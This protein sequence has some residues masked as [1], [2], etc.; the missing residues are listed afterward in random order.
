MKKQVIIRTTDKVGKMAAMFLMM[1]SVSLNTQGQQQSDFTPIMAET[2]EDTAQSI[3][4]VPPDGATPVESTLKGK[5][6]VISAEQNGQDVLAEME[7]FAQSMETSLAEF[8]NIEFFGNGKFIVTMMG[9]EFEDSY[10]TVDNVT[11]AMETRVRSELWMKDNNVMILG[12]DGSAIVF[13]STIS[14]KEE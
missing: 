13:S 8:C 6:Y 12:E 11:V 2:D 4:I 14:K 9:A 3:Q 1:L 7:A 10:K 5:F